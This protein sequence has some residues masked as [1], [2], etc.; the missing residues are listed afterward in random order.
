MR[1]SKSVGRDDTHGVNE[2]ICYMTCVRRVRLKFENEVKREQRIS[3][4]KR[5]RTDIQCVQNTREYFM[6]ITHAYY[7]FIRNM[8]RVWNVWLYGCVCKCEMRLAL[9]FVVGCF[10]ASFVVNLPME[11]LRF[12][13]RHSAAVAVPSAQRHSMFNAVGCNRF[14][15]PAINSTCSH[16]LNLSVV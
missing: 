1:R 10:I 3:R 5:Q 6:L 11:L 13:L 4:Y 8:H 12:S 7:Y 2:F 15:M 14:G 9:C 16:S